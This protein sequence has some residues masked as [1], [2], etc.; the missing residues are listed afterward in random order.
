MEKQYVHLCRAERD[1]IFQLLKAGISRREISKRLGRS[2]AT[3]SREILRNGSYL[4]YLPDTAEATARGRRVKG[5]FKIDR[6]PELRQA[7]LE[8][9]AKRW[10]PED[11]AHTCYGKRTVCHETIYRYITESPFAIKL[12]LYTCLWRQK[13]RRRKRTTRKSRSKIH[14]RVS[15][16]A[17]SNHINN[18]NHYHH[19]E[20]DLMH[21][22]KQKHNLITAIERKSRYLLIVSN[23]D[24]KYAA[25]VTKRLANA[26]APFKP[27][28]ITLDNG[29]EFAHHQNL[30]SKTFFCD[31]YSSW[32]KGSI[33][34]ANGRIRRWLPKSHQ[35]TITQN[36]LDN[37][38]NI[39]NNKP[40]KILGWKT[41]AQVFNRCTSF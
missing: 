24:G 20:A 26:I 16:H 2:P 12:G 30:P 19:W 28:S 17:R 32:Q 41:P 38:A 11:I 10:S 18:R 33:E 39:L 7:L 40:R 31:P 34:H 27:K 8:G 4:G 15:I 22:K 6:Y 37:I 21:F 35:G 5:T 14:G 1:E 9:L 25:P 3:I 29:L 13:P 36:M 23:P